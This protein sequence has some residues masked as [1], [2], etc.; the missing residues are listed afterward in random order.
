MIIKFFLG[1]YYIISVS[2]TKPEYN[3]EKK[4]TSRK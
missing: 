2:K 1:G 4:V 3:M